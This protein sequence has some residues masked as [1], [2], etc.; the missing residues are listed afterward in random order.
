MVAGVSCW[1]VAALVVAVECPALADGFGHFS[2]KFGV[3]EGT[4]GSELPL[5]LFLSGLLGGGLEDGDPDKNSYRA[6][7]FRMSKRL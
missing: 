7:V 4:N 1:H 2:P 6:R 5:T 3:G